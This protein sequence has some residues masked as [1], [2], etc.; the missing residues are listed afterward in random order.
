MPN[1]VIG[2]QQGQTSQVMLSEVSILTHV[3]HLTVICDNPMNMLMCLYI[4]KTDTETGKER[5]DIFV[6]KYYYVIIL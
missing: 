4:I 5:H 1:L 3:E 2:T 6:K